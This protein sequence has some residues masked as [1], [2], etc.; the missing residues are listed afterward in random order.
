[1]KRTFKRYQ[2]TRK[3]TR[4]KK[5]TRRRTKTKIN[6]R[7]IAVGMHSLNAVGFQTM[8]RQKAKS[9]AKNP[10]CAQGNKRN[11]FPPVVTLRMRMKM[12]IA[13]HLVPHPGMSNP[14]E[15]TARQTCVTYCLF[16]WKFAASILYVMQLM[17]LH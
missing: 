14:H 6:P 16:R 11:L 10:G 8:N 4:R 2:M 1:M 5:R 15:M 17:I 12:T 3:K 7:T 13:G 9:T